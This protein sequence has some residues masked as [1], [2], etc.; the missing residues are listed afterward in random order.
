MN[1]EVNGVTITLTEKQLAEIEKQL[2]KQIL[3]ELFKELIKNVDVNK[4]IVDFE[5]YPNSMF[6]FDSDECIF[7]YDFK[8]HAFLS[9]YPK[10]W[11][12]FECHFNGNYNEIQL[13]MNSMVEEHFKLKGV[14]TLYHY[15]LKI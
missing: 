15:L 12:N 5:K 2:N 4:P 10:I 8:N 14:T 7:E 6:W 11:E 1:I 9:N 13:F 3:E